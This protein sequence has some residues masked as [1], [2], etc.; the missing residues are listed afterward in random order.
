M[1][2]AANAKDIVNDPK[3]ASLPHNSDLVIEAGKVILDAPMPW[4]RGIIKDFKECIIGHWW[5]EMINFNFKTVAVTLF[6]FIAVIAPTL[7]FGA[8]Y[9][10]STNNA[11]GAI[12]TMVATAWVGTAYAVFGGMPLCVIGST[13]PV[14]AFTTALTDIAR[15]ID[16]PFLPFYGWCSIWLVGYC[17][18]AAFFDST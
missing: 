7:T 2:P 13:G 4:G 17:F 8:V 11:I 16:V 14:L 5:E 9:G 15:A 1:C 18:V 3:Q 6:L 12:E 10:K